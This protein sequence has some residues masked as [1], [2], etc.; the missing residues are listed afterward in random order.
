MQREIT[1]Q[2]YFSMKALDRLDY[3]EQI[4]EALWKWQPSVRSN[5]DKVLSLGINSYYEDCNEAALD[6][7]IQVK[8]LELVQALRRYFKNAL[9]E[10]GPVCILLQSIIRSPY[11]DFE[12]RLGTINFYVCNPRYPCHDSVNRILIDC[13]KELKIEA[14]EHIMEINIMLRKFHTNIV[15]YNKGTGKWKTT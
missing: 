15:K 5:I 11:T 2:E 8:S 9:E 13:L 6:L 3:V 14:N 1:L 12:T 10:P 7:F 4:S